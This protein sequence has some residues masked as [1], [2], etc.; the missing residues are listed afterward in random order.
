MNGIIHYLIYSI[1]F[2]KEKPWTCPICMQTANCY[3]SMVLSKYN[4]DSHMLEHILIEKRRLR[5]SS[6]AVF[7]TPSVGSPN[8]RVSDRRRRCRPLSRH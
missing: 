5:R 4:T 7:A 1:L 8:A 6:A 2:Y 3:F